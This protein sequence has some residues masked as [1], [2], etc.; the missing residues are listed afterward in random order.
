MNIAGAGDERARPRPQLFIPN[1]NATMPSASLLGTLM[2]RIHQ[3]FV[4]VSTP[5]APVVA[6]M[7][8]VEAATVFA[9]VVAI[10]PTA[11]P[12]ARVVAFVVVAIAPL[13]V[14]I[15][16]VVT[17]IVV[18]VRVGSCQG[19]S[20]CECDYRCEESCKECTCEHEFSLLK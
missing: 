3:V 15:A 6:A 10:A 12:V 18:V 7:A 11:I 19:R 14:P 16:P 1:S 5:V 13:V 2:A 4:S 9:V 17:A 20:H 8:P